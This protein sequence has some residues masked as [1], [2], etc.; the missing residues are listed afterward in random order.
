MS[1]SRSLITQSWRCI[2]SSWHFIGVPRL[3]EE[4]EH[5]LFNKRG[6]V[7]GDG[8]LGF[9]DEAHNVRD[10]ERGS[11]NSHGNTVPGHRRFE[12]SGQFGRNSHSHFQNHGVPGGRS[13]KSRLRVSRKKGFRNGFRMPEFDPGNDQLKKIFE[14]QMGSND[15]IGELDLGDVGPIEGNFRDDDD[16]EVEDF[17]KDA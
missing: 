9:S 15:P 5:H 13:T 6:Y 8:K 1:S 14:S 4:S 7:T 16:S 12:S 11:S 17:Y 2:L 3:K 10:I